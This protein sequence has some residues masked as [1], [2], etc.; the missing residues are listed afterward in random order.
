MTEMRM[1]VDRV[2]TIDGTAEAVKDYIPVRQTV[3]FAPNEV[4]QHVDIA[5]VDDNEWE[6]DEV[7]FVKLSLD[8]DDETTKSFQVLDDETTP[9]TVLGKRQPL[10][11]VVLGKRAIQEITILNDDGQSSKTVHTRRLRLTVLDAYNCS[12]LLSGSVA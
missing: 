4:L 2:E 1:N 9:M 6:P 12:Y 5:I 8:V 10:G 11:A 3:A 7:F